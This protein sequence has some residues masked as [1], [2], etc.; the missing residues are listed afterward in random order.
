MSEN[1]K[2]HLI[3]GPGHGMEFDKE[4]SGP[5]ERV[6]NYDELEGATGKHTRHEYRL[7]KL[8]NNRLEYTWVWKDRLTAIKELDKNILKTI[9]SVL[10]RLDTTEKLMKD[11]SNVTDELSQF[12]SRMHTDMGNLFSSQAEVMTA[13][14][15]HISSFEFRIADHTGRLDGQRS[16]IDRHDRQ[17]EQLTKAVNSLVENSLFGKPAVVTNAQ[18]E[19][20]RRAKVDTSPGS[21]GMTFDETESRRPTEITF[22]A[23][24]VYELQQIVYWAESDALDRAL[25]TS[26]S[27]K[28]MFKLMDEW[29]KKR[30]PML[31]PATKKKLNMIKDPS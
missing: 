6:F 22:T 23:A 20:I 2:I 8:T 30:P 12:V 31:N 5:A 18:V 16:N 24:E 1:F 21:S 10:V 19:K 13:I 15:E 14:N 3:G 25:D 17:I 11:L 9:D 26:I 28:K 27:W 7:T 4:Y 29:H